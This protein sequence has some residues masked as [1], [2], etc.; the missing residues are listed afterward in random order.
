MEKNYNLVY[1]PLAEDDLI[2]IIDY[3]RLDDPTNAAN[4][5]SRF[6]DAVSKLV[7]FPFMGSVPKDLNLAQ[8]NYRF[9]AVESFLVFYVVLDDTV[10]IRRILSGKRKY[11]ALL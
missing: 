11:D 1:L 10:E 6:D 5:L 8:M 2:E 3:V 9:L 7:F 4:L